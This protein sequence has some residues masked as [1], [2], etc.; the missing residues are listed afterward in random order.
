MHRKLALLYI[1]AERYQDAEIV[2]KQILLTDPD[3]PHTIF[4]L[5]QTYLCSNEEDN[6]K[7]YLQQLL[8]SAEY[9]SSMTFRLTQY[10]W[11]TNRKNLLIFALRTLLEDKVDINQFLVVARCLLRLLYKFYEV[12][13]GDTSSSTT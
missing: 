3:N 11:E 12:T 6:F 4:M 9:D 7:M 8:A 13:L 2:L 10:A 1:Q 5:C